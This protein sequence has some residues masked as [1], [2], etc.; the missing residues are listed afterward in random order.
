MPTAQ[1]TWGNDH[2]LDLNYDNSPHFATLSVVKLQGVQIISVQIPAGI[3]HVDFMLAWNGQHEN[4]I[5]LYVRDTGS[6][7]QAIRVIFFPKQNK[8]LLWSVLHVQ[9]I[10]FDTLNFVDMTATQ[11]EHLRAVLM[12]T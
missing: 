8:A 11:L 1:L 7:Y 9:D 10:P 5:A 2:L 6:S 3:T 12:V 4:W